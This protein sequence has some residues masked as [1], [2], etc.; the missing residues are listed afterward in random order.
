[1]GLCVSNEIEA[2]VF[3]DR[4]ALTIC[5]QWFGGF[6]EYGRV[7]DAS[8]FN[9]S[10]S[11]LEKDAVQ[12]GRSLWQWRPELGFPFS[13]RIDFL[14]KT[15]HRSFQVLKFR[16]M[17]PWLFQG[18]GQAQ[19]VCR[20][21]TLMV[22]VW[23]IRDLRDDRVVVGGETWNVCWRIHVADYEDTG[24]IWSEVSVFRKVSMTVSC[25]DY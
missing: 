2:W 5:W 8:C 14:R 18:E 21:M 15:E 25:F 17:K 7:S 19:K 20:H 24:N 10:V 13:G 11:D 1:M 22:D 6:L 16:C 3:R 23:W 9:S 12:N 4:K